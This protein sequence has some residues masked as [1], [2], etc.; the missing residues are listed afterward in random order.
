[1]QGL[2]LNGLVG[3]RTDFKLAV[4]RIHL[5]RLKQIEHETGSL[6]STAG[7]GE[8]EKELDEFLYQIVSAKESLLQEINEKVL[9]SKISLDDVRLGTVNRELYKVGKSQVT[10]ELNQICNPQHW[11]WLLNDFH[12]HSKHR[13]MISRHI[14]VNINESSVRTKLIHPVTEVDIIP[15][16]D[17]M[18]DKMTKLASDT[19]SLY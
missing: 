1:M 18:L 7:I 15:Y 12:N 16:C 3:N 13:M 2:S 19:R 17:D 14:F 6:S 11:L 8:A 10:R 5:D 9:A 4:C